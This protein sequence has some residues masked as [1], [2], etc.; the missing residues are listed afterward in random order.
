MA[1]GKADRPG[2]QIKRAQSLFRTTADRRLRDLG[3]TM[4]GYALLRALADE[5]GISSADLARRV[6]V[7][8]QTLGGVVAGL[9]EQGWVVQLEPDP[10]TGGRVRPLMISRSGRANLDRAERI[11][12]G[13]ENAAVA[14]LT[15]AERSELTR[16]L[17]A[18]A[19]NL[20]Q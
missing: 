5:P 10:R 18:Y 19:D 14:G 8:R 17:A 3:L 4:A 7:T 6:F 15:R 12:T 11:V 9:V 2:Y 13:V 20:T 1:Q 16:L